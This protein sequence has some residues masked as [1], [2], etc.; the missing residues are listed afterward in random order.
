MYGASPI[1]EATLD[2]A[3]NAVPGAEL[4]QLYGMT[5]LSPVC[6]VLHHR[7]LSGEGR[8]KNRHRSAGRPTFG[9]E[10]TVFDENEAVAPVG[11]VGEIVVRGPNVMMGYWNREKETADALRGGWMHTGDGGYRD[12]DGFI[13]VCDRIKDMII[14]GGENVYS[15]EVEN[16]LAKH[17]AVKQCAVVGAPDA[18]WGER[19][20][21]V[22]VLRDQ[23]GV[24]AEELQAWCREA[25]AGFKLPRSFDFR[26]DPLPVSAAGKILKREL[27]QALFAAQAPGTTSVQ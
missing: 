10:V 24:T 6:T 1:S 7:E 11:Q 21:A 4:I 3:M 8:R 22:V 26:S 16:V 13:H 2:R 19:V 27:R 23:P 17:P 14:S 25:L 9:V 5:E 20:H 12:A 15:V 18:D